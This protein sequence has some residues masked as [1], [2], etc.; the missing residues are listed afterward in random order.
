M[1]VTVHPS[2]PVALAEGLL[3]RWRRIPVSVIVDLAP[4]R[5][6]DPA[7]KALHPAG[8]QPALFGRAVTAR[9][10]PP[11][12]GAVLHAL[13]HVE[14]GNVLVI[15]AG[16]NAAYAMIG[17]VLG[18]HL[19]RRGAAGVVCDGAIRDT[20]GLAAMTGFSV[21]SRAVNPRGPTGAADGDVNGSVD[22]GGCAVNP[23]DLIIGDGDGLAALTPAN[24][25]SLIDAAE[26]KLA[27]EADWTGRLTAGDRVSEIF[28]L[29]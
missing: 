12:F 20:A 25:A 27:L 5:Q 1:T 6:I 23:G 10:E 13:E 28:G 2:Q 29:T 21:Y 15:A 16:G 8:R 22:I 17:D 14:P 24:L 19:H 26:A 18:G 4:D 11:D 9:C 3:A 7:I